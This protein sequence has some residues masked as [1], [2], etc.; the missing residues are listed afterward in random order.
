MS[1]KSIIKNYVK[2]FLSQKLLKPVIESLDD[3]QMNL[4]SNALFDAFSNLINKYLTWKPLMSESVNSVI[5][6]LNTVMIH[7][8]DKDLQLVLSDLIE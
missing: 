8:K 6:A 7:M 1:E 5:E 2:Q 4:L 3:D